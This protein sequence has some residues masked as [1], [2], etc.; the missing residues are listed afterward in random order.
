M[1]LYFL[2]GVFTT[3]L[4]A[5]GLIHIGNIQGELHILVYFIIGLSSITLTTTF[6][7]TIKKVDWDEI[8][9][10]WLKKKGDKND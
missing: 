3:I 7:A 1:V 9:E 6:L 10:S 8:M 5:P 2:G 4:I